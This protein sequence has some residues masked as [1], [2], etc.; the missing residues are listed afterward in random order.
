MF[1]LLLSIKYRNLGRWL[2]WVALGMMIVTPAY[3]DAIS[4]F[5]N[6][7][8]NSLSDL[9]SNP[10]GMIASIGTQIPSLMQMVTAVSYVLG[11]WMLI[12][13]LM[14]FKKFGEQR[15]MM[16][17]EH[18]VREPITY[19]IVGAMMLYLPTSIQVGMSTFFANP[20]PYG[21]LEVTDTQTLLIQNGYMIVQLFGTIAFIRGL[22]ILS[23]TGGHHGGQ[24]GDMGK[25]LTHVIG[26]LLCIN[27]FQ[28]LQVILFTIGVPTS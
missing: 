10:D 7:L 19:F 3:A 14:K 18:H 15:T 23:H 24:Q 17:G 2:V 13:S 22:I 20:S 6:S 26:G 28:V 5:I 4:D 8:E 16:S 21:Y 1:R 12:T 25:G 9:T 27:I 11:M